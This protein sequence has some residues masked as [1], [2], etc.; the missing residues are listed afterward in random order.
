MGLRKFRLSAES[1]DAFCVWVRI[2]SLTIFLAICILGCDVL[3][4][5]LYE[6]AFGESKR[7]RKRH[8]RSCLWATSE[9]TTVGHQLHAERKAPST[10]QVIEMNRERGNQ[11]AVSAWPKV[12]EEVAYR[13][14][15]NSLAQWKPRT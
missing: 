8:A 15:A 12:H 1:R 2:M 11:T 13:R 10:T 4:Y 14:L 6:W 9:E 5:F 3:I 7:I